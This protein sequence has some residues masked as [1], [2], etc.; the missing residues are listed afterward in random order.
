MRSP[1]RA[2]SC[3]A[4]TSAA[5]GP[6]RA[7]RTDPRLHVRQVYVVGHSQGSLEAAQVAAQDPSLAGLVLLGGI[8]QPNAQLFAARMEA[9]FADRL[10][11]ASPA[12][13]PGVEKYVALHRRLIAIAAAV[14]DSA[15]ALAQMRAAAPAFGVS[16]EEVALQ[17][18]PAYLE[19]T[20]HDILAQDPTPYLRRIRMPVLALTGALDTETPAATQLPALQ[21]QLAAAGN[22]HVTTTVVPQV[23]HFFQ[24]NLP[25]QKK[26][27]YDNPETFSPAELKLLNDWLLQQAKMPPASARSPR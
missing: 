7:L 3:C 1:G 12:D 20:M 15:A 18:A 25:G 9:N 5:W 16:A 8:G 19:H 17:Y 11:A 4:T 27:L 14:P 24:T 13:K 26:S 21:A 6:R 23:N 10:A 22:Q 2:L